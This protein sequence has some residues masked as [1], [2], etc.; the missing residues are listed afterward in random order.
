MEE[1]HLSS[2]TEPLI[3]FILVSFNQ[4]NL[5]KSS[6]Q[7]IKEQK[8]EFPY[9]I[10]VIDTG[11]F[12]KT[13]LWISEQTEL[14]SFFTHH[15][16]HNLLESIS[17]GVNAAQGK[18]TCLMGNGAVLFPDAIENA[19]GFYKD[20]Q[21]Q[22]LLGAITFPTKII[23]KNQKFGVEF[24]AGSE[25][26]IFTLGLLTTNV[27]K[28]IDLE[29]L[30]PFFFDILLTLKLIDFGYEVDEAINSFASISNFPPIDSFSIN[31]SAFR[32]QFS[33][34]MEEQKINLKTNQW[35]IDRKITSPQPT[36]GI[37][38]KKIYPFNLARL[39]ALP[40]LIAYKLNRKNFLVS[41]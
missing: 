24:F 14:L 20:Y 25:N 6:I 32:F 3:S 5:L 36:N 2:L 21:N 27:I 29:S 12:R 22:E 38:E 17:L 39:L 4:L 41:G 35:L 16:N 10:I 31:F 13:K 23:R 28:N 40:K 1:I 15:K 26:P 9:E 8:L 37:I 19:L 18:F 34:V 11:S 33:Q 30:N 7:S